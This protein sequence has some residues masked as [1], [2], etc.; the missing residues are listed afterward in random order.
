MIVPTAT[1]AEH[2]R[3]EFARSATPVRP[4]QIMTLE[5]FLERRTNAPPPAPPSLV[6]W[7][8]RDSLARLKPARF[9][10]IARYRG[11]HQAVAKL[12]DEAPLHVFS[13]DLKTLLGDVERSLESRGFASRNAR[14]TAAGEALSEVAPTIVVDGFFQF[15]AAEK[16]L[17]LAMARS[18]SITITLPESDPQLLG[19]GFVEQRLNSTHRA[20]LIETFSAPALDR[21][22]EEIAHQILNQAARGHAFREMGVIVRVRDPYAPALR[23]AFERFAIP[24]RFYFADP[25]TARPAVACLCGIVRAMLDGWDHAKLLTALRMPVS[26][27]GATPHGDRFDFEARARLPAAGLPLPEPAAFLETF[28]PWRRARL[29]AKEWCARLRELRGI[30]PRP[31]IG[32]S[33]DREEV[34]RWHSTTSAL[35]AFDAA[36]EQAAAMI[37]AD[38]T[39]AEFWERAELALSLD[40]GRPRDRRRNVVH[41]MDV[42][43]ARQWE[44][45]VVFVCGMT[46]RHFPQYH[47]EDSLFGDAARRRAG[48]E[49]SG[50]RQRQE[51]FLFDLAISRATEKTILSYSRFNEKGEETL[52]SFFLEKAAPAR[53]VRVRPRPWRGMHAAPRPAVHADALLE[54]LSKAH[55]TLA[56]TSIESFLQCPYQFFAQK[57]LK[58]RARPAAPRDR[59]DVLLQGNIIHFALAEATR[60]PLYRAAIFDE[61]FEEECRKARVPDGYRREAVRLEM[62]RNFDAFWRDE[63]V[64]LGWTSRVEEKFEFALSPILSIRGRIDRIDLGPHG[65]ALVIDYKYSAKNKIR[66]RV[67]DDADGNFVQGGLYLLAAEKILRLAPAGMLFCG[68]RKEIAW[69]G[70][71]TVI[72]GLEQVGE[73]STQA[74]IRELMDAAAAK[75]AG[76]FEQIASGVI[77]PAPADED[78]CAWCDYRDICRIESAQQA[79]GAGE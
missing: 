79:R 54:Q 78:K 66:R 46:E 24:A 5:N 62:A 48:L 60:M 17:L 76:A 43:E 67:R 30:V 51:R 71:H 53:D 8:I 58:L 28:D 3:H 63:K 77:A 12:L 13:G 56:P 25:L 45:P 68:L 65:E 4:G 61:V 14:L 33:L 31:T 70:W 2:V 29:S 23:S 37:D 15:S 69:D 34:E 6:H 50:A 73:V 27:I 59:L 36:I 21:E 26:G 44:L 18:S 47:R 9:E 72:R 75:A 74:R 7:L 11:F 20:P 16:T 39:L 42:F 19:A 38:A 1:M 64:A 35:E 10:A 41:V 40:H 55:K 22:V 52:R 49:T 57:T 32:E